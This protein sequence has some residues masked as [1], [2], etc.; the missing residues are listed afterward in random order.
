MTLSWLQS[1]RCKDEDKFKEFIEPRKISEE[2]SFHIPQQPSGTINTIYV[3]VAKKGWLDFCTHPRDPVLQ[4]VKE[5]YSNMLQ[6][7]QRTIMVK[8]VQV[9][10]DLKVINA[11]YNLPFDMDFEY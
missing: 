2:K 8:N 9:P 1:R 3:A 10:L 5:F 11:F 4:I 6:Q 7:D